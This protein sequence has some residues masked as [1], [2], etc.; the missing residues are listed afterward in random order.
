MQPKIVT[1]QRS[2]MTASVFDWDIDWRGKSAGDTN[3]GSSEVVYGTFPRWIGSPQLNLC[4]E[5]LPQ[6]RAIRA[7][8]RGR[9]NVYRVPLIDASGYAKKMTAQIFDLAGQKG[10]NGLSFSNQLPTEFQPFVLP[11]VA[12]LKGAN[13][14]IIDTTPVPDYVP[15]VGEILSNKDFPFIVTEVLLTGTNEYTL[16]VEM[17]FREA[18][19]A[20]EAIDVIPYGLFKVASDTSGNPSYDV[21]FRSAPKFDFVEWMR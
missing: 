19:A 17:P 6:W 16:S 8:A 3:A 9:V 15:H 20:G 14:V 10:V 21:N 12:V 11:K 5:T 18:I 13:S 2:L 1:I 7:S 4:Q